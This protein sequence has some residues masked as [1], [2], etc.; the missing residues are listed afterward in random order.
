MPE[1]VHVVIGLCH[2]DHNPAVIE[3]TADGIQV[4]YLQNEVNLAACGS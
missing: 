2:I 1:Q 3:Q 4:F